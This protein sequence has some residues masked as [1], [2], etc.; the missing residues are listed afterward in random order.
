M[1]EEEDIKRKGVNKMKEELIVVEK[2]VEAIDLAKKNRNFLFL[3]DEE[4][5]YFIESKVLVILHHRFETKE[6]LTSR[7]EKIKELEDYLLELEVDL[8]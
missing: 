1:V 4:C 7:E 8:L 6:Y 2:L 3:N 5:N